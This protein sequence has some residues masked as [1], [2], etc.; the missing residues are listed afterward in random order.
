[1]KRHHGL[2]ISSHGL[3]EADGTWRGSPSRAS[4]GLGGNRVVNEKRQDSP[5][6]TLLGL[7]VESR[8]SPHISLDFCQYAF[9]ASLAGAAFVP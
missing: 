4:P 6:R 2:L 1:V 7:D 8:F 9:F 5:S 3:R